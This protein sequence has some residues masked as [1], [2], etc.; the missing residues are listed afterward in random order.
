MRIIPQKKIEHL[1]WGPGKE[2]PTTTPTTPTPRT[3]K[4]TDI[5]AVLRGKEFYSNATD[6]GRWVG[7]PLALET[8][9]KEVGFDGVLTMPELIAAKISADK[10][11][12]F[13]KQWYTVHTEE[14]IGIDTAG[15]FCNRGEPVLVIVNGGGILTPTRIRK[16]YA[17]G[18][19]NGAAKYDLNEEFD[20]LLDK[21]LPDGRTIP[22]YTIDML[23]Q[24][25]VELPHAHAIVMPYSMAQATKSGYLKKKAFIE[26]PLVIARIG[27]KRNAELYHDKAKDSDGEVRNTHPYNN[28]DATQTQGR[29]LFLDDCGLNGDDDLYDD[30]RFVGV[31]PEARGA[32]KK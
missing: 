26:N 15:R 11:H 24:D 30:G 19:L 32:Q 9:Q 23:L 5:D 4:R 6:S 10:D 20:P 28:A 12:I 18:L 13:W 21:R 8:A 22:F 3:I 1:E 31:A 29:L 14:N 17:D 27:S 16:G 7:L 2:Q 25:E